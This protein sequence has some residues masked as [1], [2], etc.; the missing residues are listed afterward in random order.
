MTLACTRTLLT[1]L[2]ALILKNAGEEQA[3]NTSPTSSD[4]SLTLCVNSNLCLLQLFSLVVSLC[5]LGEK[6]M[7]ELANKCILC[8][9]L[10][11]QEALKPPNAM[12]RGSSIWSDFREASNIHRMWLSCHSNKPATPNISFSSP[13]FC[14]ALLFSL[15]SLCMF[16]PLLSSRNWS[17]ISTYNNLI[18]YCF[19]PWKSTRLPIKLSTVKG[20]RNIPAPQ[21]PHKKTPQKP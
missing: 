2:I 12:G 6:I 16:S 21:K 17:W 19:F 9:S 14:T 10:G 1:F 5:P 18:K 13:V 20:K 4:T 15:V 8:R 11:D 3:G 7:A